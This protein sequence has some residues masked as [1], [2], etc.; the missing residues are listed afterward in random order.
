[1]FWIYLLLRDHLRLNNNCNSILIAIDIICCWGLKKSLIGFLIRLGLSKHWSTIT[2]GTLDKIDYGGNEL[3][4]YGLGIIKYDPGN[5]G[6]DETNVRSGI[7]ISI[8]LIHYLLFFH[9]QILLFQKVKYF[10][11]Y[12]SLLALNFLMENVW[13]FLF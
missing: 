8:I 1:M 10:I 5:D 12:F 13:H 4:G 6:Y 2:R 3:N 11:E 7:F 9:Y